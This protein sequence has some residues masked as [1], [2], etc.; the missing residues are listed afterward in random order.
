V[1]EVVIDPSAEEVDL[2]IKASNMSR[3]EVANII[4]IRSV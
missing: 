1:V 4:D 3:K 2:L